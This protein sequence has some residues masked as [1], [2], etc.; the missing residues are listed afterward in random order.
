MP[1]KFLVEHCS[2][3]VVQSFKALPLDSKAKF[4]G[5]SALS[6]AFGTYRV[7]ADFSNLVKWLLESLKISTLAPHV[8]E[9]L[10]KKMWK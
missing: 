8:S 6:S 9:F 10:Y 3:V 1:F 2:T 5:I 4:F 7:L